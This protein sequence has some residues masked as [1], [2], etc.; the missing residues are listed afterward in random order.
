M[1][2]VPSGG[3]RSARLKT[4]AI[5]S[6]AAE[7]LDDRP[8]IAALGAAEAGAHLAQDQRDDHPQVLG[9]GL[10]RCCAGRS[11]AASIAASRPWPGAAGRQGFAFN[12]ASGVNLRRMR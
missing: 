7:R 9:P 12:R 11:E 3:V 8:E 2:L 6:D 4:I 10:A 1:K 5:I